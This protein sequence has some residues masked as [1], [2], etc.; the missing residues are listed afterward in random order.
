VLLRED[1]RGVL[2]IGQQSHAWISGQLARG[3]GNERFGAPSPWEELCLAAE[4]HDIGF[5]AWDLEPQLDPDTDLPYSFVEM[6]LEQHLGLWSTAPERLLAQS[7]YVAL[8]VS[9]HGSRLYRRRDLERLEPAQADAVRAYL[10]AQERFREPLIASLEHDPATVAW[11]TPPLLARNSQLVWIWDFLSLAI[12][13]NWI[14]RTARETPALDGP[15]DIEILPGPRPG[16]AVLEP[17]PF[18]EHD[19]LAVRCEARRLHAGLP[20]GETPWERLEFE[21]FAAA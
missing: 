14:P 20:F 2:A 11:V 12:C 19:S 13:L 3:W 8:L 4:Q 16:T 9:M 18:R 10:R 6:P 21:F 7:R 5:A 15:V 1:D 17:W